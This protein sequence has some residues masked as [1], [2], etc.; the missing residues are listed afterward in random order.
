M[1]HET[2]NTQILNLKLLRKRKPSDHDDVGD[3]DNND[4]N[5]GYD[6]RELLMSG[7][8]LTCNKLNYSV[9]KNHDNYIDDNDE[10]D[11]N[12]MMTESSC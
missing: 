4:N 12:N 1:K 2:T 7:A 9:A 6:D 8:D 3:D 5:N 10:D 11:D